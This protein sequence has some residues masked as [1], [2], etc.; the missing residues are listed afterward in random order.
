MLNKWQ[1][2]KGQ[3]PSMNIQCYLDV[4]VVTAVVI[5][6]EEDG[7]SLHGKLSNL[8]RV[9]IEAYMNLKGIEPH[10]SVSEA[11]EQLSLLG[12]SMKQLGGVHGRGIL[13]AIQLE[14]MSKGAVT[15]SIDPNSD[16][17]KGIAMAEEED[18]K[19]RGLS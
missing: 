17:S 9:L 18:K 8:T 14:T 6:M 10:D 19:R 2:T 12:F 5:K 15:T 13:N 4:R 3:H 1:A 7:I 16:I 11:V